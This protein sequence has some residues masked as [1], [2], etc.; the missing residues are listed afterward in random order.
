M[1]TGPFAS[2]KSTRKLAKNNQAKRYL[3]NPV[4]KEG[5]KAHLVIH[6]RDLWRNPKV[7]VGEQEAS[8]VSILPN[9]QGLLA[10]FDTLD[11]PPRRVGDKSNSVVDLKVFTSNGLAMLNNAV[12]IV[13]SD[14]AALAEVALQTNCI[15]K[16]EKQN[17]EYKVAPPDV[18]EK[19][20]NIQLL[21]R[22]KG[23]Y[24]ADWQTSGQVSSLDL[25]KGD[26]VFKDVAW[27]EAGA[28]G[29][30]KK[31]QDHLMESNLKIQYR[32]GAD[33]EKLGKAETAG[34]FVYFKDAESAK[35]KWEKTALTYSLSKEDG[36]E[37]VTLTDKA[38]FKLDKKS[39]FY[40][41][42]P[43]LESTLGAK[44][45]LSVTSVDK[46]KPADPIQVESSGA[47]DPTGEVL[48]CPIPSEGLAEKLQPFLTDGKDH[49]IAFG[50]SYSKDQTL[51]ITGGLEFKPKK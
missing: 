37:K 15:I 26:L 30:G 11:L 39:L 10:E 51:A 42:Y 40:K 23:S 38:V 28:N 21:I 44:F 7:F 35:P 32:P 41:A 33:F 19:Y 17:L 8:N 14:A 50:I 25:N 48:S 1:E 3:L 2:P 18:L 45:K 27:K 20:S 9:M 36:A 43:G 34:E 46:K 4:T 49:D 29:N 24:G 22:P 16:G 6:G 13:A 47:C 31:E 12:E 5:Q